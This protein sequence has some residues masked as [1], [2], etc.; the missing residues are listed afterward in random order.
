MDEDD[1]NFMNYMILKKRR[2]ESESIKQ[3]R[4]DLI[5]YKPGPSARQACLDYIAVINQGIKSN[6]MFVVG[7]AIGSLTF[8]IKHFELSDSLPD[9]QKDD[10]Q[11]IS[12]SGVE[13]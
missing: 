8:I 1:I 3:S 2:G 9:G 5:A 13:P 10:F 7:E 6:N 12:C 11:Y 4:K